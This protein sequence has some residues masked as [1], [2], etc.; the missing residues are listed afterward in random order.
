MNAYRLKCHMLIPTAVT[1]LNGFVELQVPTQL[2]RLE[3][4]ILLGEAAYRGYTLGWV[5]P[6]QAFSSPAHFLGNGN[7]LLRARLDFNMASL[8]FSIGIPFT[9]Y[10]FLL[11]CGSCT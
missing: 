4:W 8:V 11:Q 7:F 5:P 6:C 3:K 2:R 9:A 10:E 1:A